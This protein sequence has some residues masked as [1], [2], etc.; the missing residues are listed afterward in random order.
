MLHDVLLQPAYI[1]HTRLYRDTSVLLELFT[2]DYGRVSLIARGVRGQRGRFKGILQPFVPL[3]ISWRGKTELMSMTGAEACDVPHHLVGDTLLC[4]LYLNELL[5][6]LLHRY[7]AHPNLYHVYQQTLR[8]LPHGQAVALRFFEKQLLSELG[9]ALQID[10]EA[11][12]NAVIDPEQFYYFDPA[13]GV[14]NCSNPQQQR[15]VFSG[16]TLLAIHNSEL[17]KL[18]D[19]RDAKRLLRIALA[20]LLDGKPIRSRELFL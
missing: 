12:T 19:M 13:R 9:Y 16:E 7:D 20:H 3:L 18:T 14:F 17:S 15:N 11:N 10:R 2:P 6:K 8:Q 5:M 1:L 4:G